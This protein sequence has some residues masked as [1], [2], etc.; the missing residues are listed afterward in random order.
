MAQF[1]Y[2]GEEPRVYVDYTDGDHTLEAVPNETYEL[3]TAPEDGLFEAVA[4][5]VSKP[6]ET[7]EN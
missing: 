7:V 4:K 1:I 2:K 6:T 3:I 5:K